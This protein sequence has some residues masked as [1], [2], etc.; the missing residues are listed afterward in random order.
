MEDEAGC[1]NIM[2]KIWR[3]NI[4]VPLAVDTEDFIARNV[5]S[6]M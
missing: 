5:V 4:V 1:P 6:P 3:L 2:P